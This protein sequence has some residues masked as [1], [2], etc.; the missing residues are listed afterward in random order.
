MILHR[1]CIFPK[2]ALLIRALSHYP[3]SLVSEARDVVRGQWRASRAGVDTSRRCK[4]DVSIACLSLSQPARHGVLR[5][6]EP[7]SDHARFPA[8]RNLTQRNERVWRNKK[9]LRTFTQPQMPQRRLRSATARRSASNWKRLLFFFRNAK[10]EL[11]QPIVFN[12]A[13]WNGTVRCVKK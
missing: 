11:R 10:S 5:D 4:I 8:F 13:M 9:A 6:S 3:Q 7:T 12:H 2:P 1:L